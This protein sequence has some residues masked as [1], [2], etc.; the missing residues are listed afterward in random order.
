M[1]DTRAELVG[2]RHGRVCVGK[3][4]QAL[5]SIGCIAPTMFSSLASSGLSGALGTRIGMRL[6]SLHCNAVGVS[7]MRGPRRL[8]G[9]FALPGVSTELVSTAP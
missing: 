6:S 7:H 4:C 5:P 1:L 2:L 9:Q 8:F 3:A